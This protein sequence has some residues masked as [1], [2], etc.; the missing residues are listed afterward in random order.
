MTIIRKLS[1]LYHE[2][3]TRDYKKNLQIFLEREKIIKSYK[4]L[5][6]EKQES[7]FAYIARRYKETEELTND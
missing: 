1:D 4:T 5:K 3:R 7:Y 2:E 6:V